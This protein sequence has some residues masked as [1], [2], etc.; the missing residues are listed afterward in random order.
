MERRDDVGAKSGTDQFP[1]GSRTDGGQG[2]FAQ[3]GA[4]AAP[5]AVGGIDGGQKEDHAVG[6]R[7]D[8]A[9]DRRKGFRRDRLGRE[10]LGGK[11][12]LY[13]LNEHPRPFGLEQRT[14]LFGLTPG[15]GE[16]NRFAGEKRTHI[17]TA[18]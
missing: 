15:P 17:K 4:S 16:K 9:I 13:R 10:R 14:R 1:F 6:A 8:H 12:L 5:V 3:K 11:D 7:K 2:D 18:V